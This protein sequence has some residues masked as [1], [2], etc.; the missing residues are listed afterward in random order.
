MSFWR[1]ISSMVWRGGKVEEDGEVPLTC[2][3]RALFR[4]VSGR[5]VRLL[6]GLPAGGKGGREYSLPFLAERVRASERY[7]HSL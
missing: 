1:E 5:V 6:L 3:R 4:L 7:V 2:R